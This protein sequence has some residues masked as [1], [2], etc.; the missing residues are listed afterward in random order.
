MLS[1]CFEVQ[2]ENLCLSAEKGGCINLLT[3]ESSH[4]VAPTSFKQI[5]QSV[6]YLLS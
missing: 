2:F 1:R 5:I 4:F 6:H 3:N